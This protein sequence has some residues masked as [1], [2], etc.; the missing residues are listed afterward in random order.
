MRTGGG[1]LCGLVLAARV[2]AGEPTGRAVLF[3]E[4]RDVRAVLR[5]AARG[6]AI[7]PSEWRFETRFDSFRENLAVGGE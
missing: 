3:S 6:D 7:P 2:W 4:A 1:A 5:F